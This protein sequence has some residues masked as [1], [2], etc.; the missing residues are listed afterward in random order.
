MNFWEGGWVGYR[1]LKVLQMLI[2]Y[3]SK[4]IIKMG[5]DLYFHFIK[6][7][8]ID[9]NIAFMQNV[10]NFLFCIYFNYLERY[11]SD[12]KEKR[13]RLLTDLFRNIKS[14]LMGGST[15]LGYKK[16]DIEE[17][18]EEILK[19]KDEEERKIKISDL[20]FDIKM[21]YMYPD[22]M[23]EL[24]DLKFNNVETNYAEMQVNL[25]LY[26]I[27]V[28]ELNKTKGKKFEQIKKGMEPLMEI[29]KEMFSDFDKNEIHKERT[30]IF[31]LRSPAGTHDDFY[32]INYEDELLRKYSSDD[33]E[34]I[35]CMFL[36]EKSSLDN[37]KKR[38]LDK[39]V[40]GI[41]KDY[42]LKG[43]EDYEL[44][45]ELKKSLQLYKNAVVKLR[46]SHTRKYYFQ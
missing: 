38:S 27:L 6:D 9:P 16:I 40:N 11:R 35:E 30:F 4:D 8:L 41:V 23:A 26:C 20:D 13:N 10:D 28:N 33:D 32:N 2:S 19:E 36:S 3:L 14:L 15:F 18:V 37:N 42:Y 24:I 46:S 34:D 45:N 25:I 43:K 21:Y 12:I 22:M 1:V 31:P 44:K 5:Y 7:D 17:T 29:L 39:Y